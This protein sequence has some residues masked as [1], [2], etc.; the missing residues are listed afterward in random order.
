[1]TQAPKRPCQ[2]KG[3]RCPHLTERNYCDR[4]RPGHSRAARASAN[5]RGYDQRWRVYTAWYKR[6][7]PLCG[8]TSR[9]KGPTGDSVCI[10]TTLASDVD[11]IVPVVSRDDPEFYNGENHQALCHSCHSKKTARARLEDE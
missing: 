5:D 8:M 9:A 1:M 2:G 11:H 7:Y 3:G 6:L 10:R 4:C